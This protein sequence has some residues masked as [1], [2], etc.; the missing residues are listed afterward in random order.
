VTT[1][2]GV[3]GMDVV[4]G[5]HGLVAED[6][7]TLAAQVCALLDDRAARVRIRAAARGLLEERYTAT[8]VMARMLDVYDAVAKGG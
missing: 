4:P 2:E 5:T 6:D 7:E 3:E 1:G 8:P